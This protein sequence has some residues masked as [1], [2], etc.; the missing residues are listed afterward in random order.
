MK[1]NLSNFLELDIKAL[2][3]VNGGSDCGGGYS[4]PSNPSAGG[5]S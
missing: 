1:F 4:P 5:G 2:L 3:A